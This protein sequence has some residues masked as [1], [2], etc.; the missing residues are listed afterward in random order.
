MPVVPSSA[1]GLVGRNRELTALVQALTRVVAGDGRVLAIVGAAG[2]GKSR[3]LGVVR[4]LAQGHGISLRDAVAVELDRDLQMGVARRLLGGVTPPDRA[5]TSSASLAEGGLASVHALVADVARRAT[6][7]PLLLCIDDLQ[8]ADEHTLLAV[9]AFCGLTRELPLGV[10][11]AWRRAE[12]DQRRVQRLL[13]LETAVQFELHD[14]GAD[15]TRTL[16]RRALPDAA[17]EF[18]DACHRVTGGNPFLLGEL[19]ATVIAD[20]VQP[21]DDAAE[22]ILRLESAT[23]RTAVLTRLGLMAPAAAALAHSVAVLG[24]A[25]PLHHAARVAELAPGE[26]AEAADAL[27]AV[28][29]LTGSEHL[30]FRH[31]LLGAVVLADIGA[32][33][34]A[35]LYRRAAEVVAADGLIDR[36]GA[37]LLRAPPGGDATAVGLLRAAAAS[38][39]RSGDPPTAVRLLK[40]A[41]AEPSRPKDRGSLLVQIARAQAALGDPEALEHLDEALIGLERS[42]ARARVLTEIARLHHVRSD[43]ARGARLAERALAEID[44]DDPS[45]EWV[46]A[47]WLM[48]A[49][50]DPERAAQTTEVMRRLAAQTLAGSPPQHP[51]LKASIAMFLICTFGDPD[52]V[53]A[54]ADDAVRGDAHDSEDGLGLAVA[55]ALSA[56]FYTGRMEMLE[57]ATALA[58]QVAAERASILTAAAAAQWRGQARIALGDPRGALEDAE[59]ALLPYRYGWKT[60]AANAAGVRALALVE[61]GDVGGAL[62]ALGTDV[63]LPYPQY[64]QTLG[65]VELAAGAFDHA[66]RAFADAG[67]ML[68]AVWEVDSPAVVPWR[69]GAAE[70]ALGTGDRA[71]AEQLSETELALARRTGVPLALGRATRVRGL[72]I[73][74]EEGIG[75][76]R[77]ACHTLGGGESRLELLRAELDLGAALRRAGARRQAREVLEGVRDRAARL[78]LVALAD[79]AR[80]EHAASG[81]R[82]RRVAPDGVGGLTP[83]ELRIAR[84]AASGQTNREIAAELFLTPKTVEWHLRHIFLK[85]EIKSRRALSAALTLGAADR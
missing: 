52:L 46:L 68:E 30:S 6:A 53:A 27:V 82:P 31:P 10:A 73:G 18:I 71:L 49:G 61:L 67:R 14:L 43:F 35:Q 36:A 13:A 12:L 59:T 39:S 70:A 77:E 7:A 65:V 29:I 21:D 72:V 58:L 28:E 4:E 47:S 22:R 75:L 85:L 80:S 20:G 81:G 56:L 16:V 24:D 19:S 44:D 74:G 66:L 17:G 60:P 83:S 32:F 34:R 41:L 51:E 57:R 62:R 64:F 26:A 37:L 15:D 84:L 40:R 38:A 45:R 50:L 78:G 42:S 79:R 55:L 48:A 2:T 5:R 54:I 33:R 69:S 8:W 3:L 23:V 25:T 9:E 1:L 11:V 76:L 63:P